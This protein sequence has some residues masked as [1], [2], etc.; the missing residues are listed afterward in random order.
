MKRYVLIVLVLAFPVVLIGAPAAAQME[1]A[2]NWLHFGYDAAYTAYNPAEHLISAANAADLELKWGIGCGDGM[3]SVIA[4]T[5]AIYDGKLFASP[6]GQGLTAYDA[7]TGSKLWSFG[8]GNLGWAPAPVVS[9]DGTVFYLEGKNTLYD[10]YAV[11]AETGGQVWQSP[12]AFDLGFSN[13]N[14]P[15]V[16]EEKGLVYFDEK[17]FAPD[18]GKLYA[19][20]EKTGAG[21]WFKGPATDNL[22]FRSDYVVL[23]QNHLYAIT[24]GANDYWKYN[25]AGIDTDTQAITQ[26]F[27]GAGGPDRSQISRQMLCGDTLLAV[28]TD[29]ADAAE[30]VGTVVAYDTQSQTVRWQKSSD[31]VVGGLACNPDLNRVYM[32][33]EPYLYALDATSGEEIWRFS[34][35]GAIYNPSIANGVVYFLSSTNMYAVDESNG[36]QL[37]FFRLGESAEPT[38]QVAISNGMVYFSGNGGDCDLYALGLPK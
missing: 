28:Y 23:G 17:P 2:G 3:F 5:P 6:A 4:R 8:A 30:S 33:S 9:A 32:A 18:E 7:L 37:F 38:S 13:T 11:D 35:F 14:L 36:Q 15:T 10:L 19:L 1:P 31:T 27:A 25:L 34:G 21:V 20:D 12:V 16:D 24:T 29:R 26:T 22:L